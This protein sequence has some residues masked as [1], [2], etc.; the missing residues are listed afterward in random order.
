MK[1][2][3]CCHLLHLIVIISSQSINADNSSNDAKAEA[4]EF[5]IDDNILRANVT[6][7]EFHHSGRGHYVSIPEM[8]KGLY[9]HYGNRIY[10]EDYSFVIRDNYGNEDYGTLLSRSCD[11]AIENAHGTYT[12]R[13][14]PCTITYHVVTSTS[15]LSANELDSSCSDENIDPVNKG[16]GRIEVRNWKDE[17]VG[18]FPR[19][20]SIPRDE[21]VYARYFCDGKKEI[22]NGVTHIQVDCTADKIALKEYVK[23][24]KNKIAGGNGY[25]DPYM[26]A[27]RAQVREFH[28][29]VVFIITLCTGACFCGL[30]CAYKSCVKP[31]LDENFIW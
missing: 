6:S 18:D 14:K 2:T 5:S 30:F 1:L 4:I 7:M 31:Y 26:K 23:K 22:P 8:C 17:C 3:I 21:A 19:C 28:L 9:D 13:K 12:S 10:E 29:V 25:E 11:S 27:Q 20:Y 15:S 16:V 24:N